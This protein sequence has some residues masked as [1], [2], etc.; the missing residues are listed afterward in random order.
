MTWANQ[1]RMLQE[2]FKRLGAVI[3]QP[4]NKKPLR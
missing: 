3:G 4:I 1:V 2:N